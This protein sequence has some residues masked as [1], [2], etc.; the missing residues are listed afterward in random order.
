MKLLSHLLQ[1][2][3]T[4]AVRWHRAVTEHFGGREIAR[5]EWLRRATFWQKFWYVLLGD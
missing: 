1:P 2:P 5:R 4:S 3:D